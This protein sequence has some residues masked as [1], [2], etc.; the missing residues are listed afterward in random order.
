M[1]NRA[2]DWFDQ[3]QRDLEHARHDLAE[4]YHEWACFSVTVA[5]PEAQSRFCSHILQWLEQP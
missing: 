1:V 2:H 4:G 3:A 5:Q